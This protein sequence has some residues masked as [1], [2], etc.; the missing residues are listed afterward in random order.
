MVAAA[1]AGAVTIT[2]TVTGIVVFVALAAACASPY[3]LHVIVV[4]H[5]VRAASEARIRNGIV[6]LA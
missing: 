4:V 2:A 6:V 3:C 1:V 5:Q